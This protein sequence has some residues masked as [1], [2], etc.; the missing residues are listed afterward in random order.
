V[1]LERCR[2]RIAQFPEFITWVLLPVFVLNQACR[3]HFGTC[4]NPGRKTPRLLRPGLPG[5]FSRYRGLR[6]LPA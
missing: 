5:L 2:T 4:E 1:R 6:R 3:N